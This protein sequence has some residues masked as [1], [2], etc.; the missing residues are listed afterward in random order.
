MTV[1]IAVAAFAAGGGAAAFV[2]WLAA[3]SGARALDV[4]IGAFPWW[5][6]AG[7]AV[8]AV[9]AGALG[10]WSFG[11]A[12]AAAA[13]V[14]AFVCALTDLRSGYVFDRALLVAALP[15]LAFGASEIVMR[16]ESAVVIGALF[17]APYL[18]SRGR[19]FGL[20]DVK[21]GVLLGAGLGFAA[22]VSMYASSFVVGAL[23]ALGALASKRMD[24][25]TVLPFAPFIALGAAIG[26]AFPLRLPA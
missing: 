21:L 9:F 22:G 13:L 19:G 24:R 11:A 23:F 25:K 3:A 26:L 17:A 15:V 20:G 14:A 10:T 8:L 6:A 4:S 7:A 2:L 16:L 1:P 12:S 5:C 18:F